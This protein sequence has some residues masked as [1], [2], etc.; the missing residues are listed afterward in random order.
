VESKLIPGLVYPLE[1]FFKRPARGLDTVCHRR[2]NL[3]TLIWWYLKGW[4]HGNKT[5]KK[6]LKNIFALKV[7]GE[8][9]SAIIQRMISET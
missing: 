6:R 8:L 3:D 2:D 1:M 7:N 5:D 9:V 4:Y